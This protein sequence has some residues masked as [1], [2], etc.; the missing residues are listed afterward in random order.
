MIWPGEDDLASA[1][2]VVDVLALLD[3]VDEDDEGGLGPGRQLDPIAGSVA[4]LGDLGLGVAHRG[5][6][7]RFSRTTSNGDFAPLGCKLLSP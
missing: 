7:E 5:Q 2:V 6:S 1:D 3:A 4:A